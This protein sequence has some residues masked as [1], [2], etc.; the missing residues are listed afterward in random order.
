[1]RDGAI[2]VQGLAKQYRIGQKERYASLRDVIAGAF[3]RKSGSNETFWALKDVSFDVSPEKCSGIIGRNG[4]GKSTLLKILSRITEPSEGCAELRGRVGSLLE[5][6][7]GFHPELTGRENIYLNGAILGM[8]RAEIQRAVRRDRRVRRGRE[9]PR[10]AGEALLERHV[11][12]PRLRG[13]RA[14]RARDPDGRRGARR[15]RRRVPGEVPGQDARRASGSGRT[16]LFVSHNM[17]SIRKLCTS[18]LHIEQGRVKAKG[19]AATVIAGY[20]EGLRAEHSGGGIQFGA[21][22]NG[23]KIDRIEVLTLDGQPKPSL[24]TWDPVRFRVFFSVRA[25][26]EWAAPSS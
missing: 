10:H 1:M 18:A 5:V 24:G 9:V 14:P 6:G 17:D 3:T 4:A 19:P 12:A 21:A 2:H 25:R 15:R 16:V 13:R 22:R 11:R 23:F 20:K 8:R 26:F 7:T